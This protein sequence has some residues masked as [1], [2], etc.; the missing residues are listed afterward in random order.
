MTKYRNYNGG[1]R[2]GTWLDTQQAWA[3][4]A[5]Q[6][7]HSASPSPGPAKA[8]QRAQP[9]L[10]K[11]G[12]GSARLAGLGRALQITRDA[13]AVPTARTLHF[14]RTHCLHLQNSPQLQKKV[15]LFSQVNFTPIHF[16]KYGE[17]DLLPENMTQK[18]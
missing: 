8:L 9:G 18:D 15:K 3:C 16:E 12:P 4:R 5:W 1:Q 13:R 6:A 10:V 17:I 2:I 14:A 11:P 7:W